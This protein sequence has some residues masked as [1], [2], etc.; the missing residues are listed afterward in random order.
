MPS[1]RSRAEFRAVILPGRSHCANPKG[2]LSKREQKSPLG[3]SH[4]HVISGLALIV[5]LCAE[6]VP[7]GTSYPALQT[8][9]FR[10]RESQPL[11]C[12]TS[13]S[14]FGFTIKTRT[15]AREGQM[16]LK[17]EIFHDYSLDE[18]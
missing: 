1:S 17:R 12:F 18:S 4:N 3:S 6:L 8:L 13:I 7:K 16:S 11:P 9:V 5:L 14:H 15:C 2:D 10:K